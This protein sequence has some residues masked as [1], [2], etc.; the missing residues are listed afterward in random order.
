M[1]VVVGCTSLAWT[2]YV[3]LGTVVTFTVGWAVSTMGSWELGARD[4][5]RT[6]G[7]KQACHRRGPD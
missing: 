7:N 3:A 1:G 4:W 6:V 2:W 5:G